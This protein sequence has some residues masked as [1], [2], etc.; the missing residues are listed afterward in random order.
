MAAGGPHS[1]RSSSG[2]KTRPQAGQHRAR[3]CISSDSEYLG[4]KGSYAYAAPSRG[5]GAGV[6][7]SPRRRRY[8][9][10]PVCTTSLV[11]RYPLSCSDRTVSSKVPG[12]EGEARWRLACARGQRPPPKRLVREWAPTWQLGTCTVY[13]GR[14]HEPG[15]WAVRIVRLWRARNPLKSFT[16]RPQTIG[17]DPTGPDPLHPAGPVRLQRRPTVPGVNPS[18]ASRTE[19]ACP[20]S[21]EAAARAWA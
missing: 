12:S 15:E 2:P 5:V 19:I 10:L 7:L 6:R 21:G 1:S 20:C 18:R 17:C 16:P 9:F 4:Y 8:T 3:C 13:E 14:C 11:L